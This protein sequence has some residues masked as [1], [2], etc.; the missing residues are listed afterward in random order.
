MKPMRYIDAILQGLQEEMARDS[1]VHIFG[2]D[3]SLGGPFGATKGLSDEFGAER[4]RNTPISESAVL[5]LAIGAA[6]VG[7]R[8]VVEVM[9]FDFITLAM[10]QLVNHAAKLHYMSNGQL[11]V[12]LTVRVQ[13]GVRGGYGAHHSQSLEAW[14]MHVPGLKVV[15]PATIA[16]AKDLLQDAI[17]DDGPVL[18]IEHRGLYWSRSEDESTNARLSMSQ[19]AIRRHGET[20]SIVSMS[21]M[22]QDALEAANVLQHEGIDVEVIDVRTL[23]PLD[24]DTIVN[25][26]KRTRRL[27]VAH[28]AVIS[29]GA[30]AEIAALV[31]ESAYGYLDAPIV[32]VAAPFSPVPT[33]PVLEKGFAPS[34]D[35]VVDAVRDV[36][37]FSSS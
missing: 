28:E 2:E 33:S 32:R 20:V 36:V 21:R 26:V 37:R 35:H 14:L 23:V 25:S 19:A 17:R 13:G 4:V 16:D 9:F 8:P 15:M 27:V 12:P 30:G 18:C 3:V 29:G 6:L 5:G 7:L 1:S 34:V 10:D 22:V 24:I 31:Q 11:R